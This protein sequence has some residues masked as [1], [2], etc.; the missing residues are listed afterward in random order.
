MITNELESSPEQG[1]YL[2][3]SSCG[4]HE[5]RLTYE[6][7]LSKFNNSAT[8]NHVMSGNDRYWTIVKINVDNDSNSFILY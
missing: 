2:L 1:Y 4:N 7:L 6:Q 3:T 5:Y 8:I